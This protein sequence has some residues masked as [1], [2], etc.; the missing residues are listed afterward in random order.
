[1][2]NI[3][4]SKFIG[5]LKVELLILILYKLLFVKKLTLLPLL[6]SLVD[7]LVDLVNTTSCFF[8]E[9]VRRGVVPS[10]GT[11][12]SWPVST[13]NMNVELIKLQNNIDRLTGL[14]HI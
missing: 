1:M 4:K 11:A 2:P 9:A 10:S 8:G 6:S 3:I 13:Q 5:Y 14:H 7:L 12:Y